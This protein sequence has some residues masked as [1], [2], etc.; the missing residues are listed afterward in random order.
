MV[1][2]PSGMIIA[3]AVPTRRPAPNIVNNFNFSYQSHKN[4]SVKQ[5]YSAL[6]SGVTNFILY[7][8]EELNGYIIWRAMPMATKE[9][10]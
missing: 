10:N 2:I 3:K 8:K 5:K 9:H 6:M 7:Q 4:S 1:A